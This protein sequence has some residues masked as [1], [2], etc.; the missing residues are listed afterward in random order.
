VAAIVATAGLSLY[1]GTM[2]EGTIGT[3]ASLHAFASLPQA[4]PFGTEL[5]G[6]LL[7]KDDIVQERPTYGN[8]AI[9]VPNKPGLG[10]DIDEDKLA[11]YRRD[12]TRLLKPV[13]ALKTGSA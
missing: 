3:V 12:K 1:G 13:V 5:F 10:V 4:F 9:A 8:F 11:H 2:L 7:L 6:P